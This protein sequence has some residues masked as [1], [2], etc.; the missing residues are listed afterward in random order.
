[1]ELIELKA[2]IRKTTGK[3]HGRKLRASDRLP[4]VLYGPG[5]E[6]TL[7]SMLQGDLSKAQKLGNIYQALFK[8]S[9][10]NGKTETHT[11]MVK[12]LQSHP[13]TREVLHVDFYEVSMDRKIRVSI[14]VTTTGTS[15]AIE[16]G[17]ILQIIRRELDV[18]CLPSEIPES[19][20]IDISNLE[21]NE[22]IHIEEIP[23]E[24]NIEIPDEGNFTVVTILA[25]K[26]E[27]EEE[28]EEEAEEGEEVAG[29][30]AASETEEAE[31]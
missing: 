29:D 19:I 4:A 20:E 9:I 18:L 28:T 23:L 5:T 8:L 3:G 17:G 12:E 25:P 31:S 14:P 11:A 27:E 30:E 7:I 21:M 16:L 2:N 10:K 15:P 1:M 6:P 22:S 26:V 13:L 24:G